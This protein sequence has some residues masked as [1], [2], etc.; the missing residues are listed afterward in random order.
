MVEKVGY[1]NKQA[2][3]IVSLDREITLRRGELLYFYHEQSATLFK[4]KVDLAGK[5][6]LELLLAGW[7]FLS[8]QRGDTR[9]EFVDIQYF[10]EVAT[11]HQNQE[12]SKKHQVV[13][14]NISVNGFAFSLS[15]SRA[16][17]FQVGDK[18]TL[19]KIEKIEIPQPVEGRI[20]HVTPL[21]KALSKDESADFTKT[22]L[23]GAKFDEPNLVMSEVLKHL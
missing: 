10:L 3:I 14:R 4:A 13:L 19:R 5:N 6:S 15:A 9:F 16:Q 23:I 12:Q 20:M 2:R 18:I 8:E 1:A 7:P 17:R 21:G 22:I 11:Y